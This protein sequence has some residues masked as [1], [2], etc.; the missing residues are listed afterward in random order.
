V[1][2]RPDPVR[3]RTTTGLERR[4][5]T[6]DRVGPLQVFGQDEGVFKGH[7][8]T[9][10]HV[11]RRGMRTIADEQH[12]PT[13]PRVERDLLDRRAM[14]WPASRNRL[15]QRRDRL[16]EVREE[17]RKLA[18]PVPDGSQ[19][20]IAVAVDAAAADG[21]RQKRRL[22]PEHHRPGVE[23]RRGLG[24]ESPAELARGP[25]DRVR[26]ECKTAGRAVDAVRPDR[27][28]VLPRAAVG[29]AGGDRRPLLPQL[30][31]LDSHPDCHVPGT[32][33]QHGVELTAGQRKARADT[34][35]HPGDVDLH[36]RPATVIAEPLPRDDG[37]PLDDLFL[38]AERA[39][40]AR[41]IA[42]QV[43]ARPGLAPVRL[44]LDDL[45]VAADAIERPRG[46]QAGDAGAGDEG[47]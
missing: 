41:C 7:G 20:D 30:D 28:V 12:A 36:E 21:D 47:P 19:A 46:C 34:A 10:S 15:E 13:H 24:D 31:D 6:G 23:L 37:R 43:D 17:G 45:D 26:A 2:L 25:H 11:R 27:E 42:G 29:E 14:H 40:R 38:E 22:A 4:E 35:P 3:A 39:E 16:G 8:R 18:F 5:G 33:E 44:A 32:L 9:L 1:R